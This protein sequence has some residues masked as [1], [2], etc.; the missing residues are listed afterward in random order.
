[1][2]TTIQAGSGYIIG[3][4][5]NTENSNIYGGYYQL[6]GKTVID[7]NQNIIVASITTQNNSI[8]AGTGSFTVGNIIAS[9]V[10]TATGINITGNAGMNVASIQTQNNYINTFSIICLNYYLFLT[11]SYR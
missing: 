8:N 2:S 3:K 7:S 5:Y 9:G 4:S 6:D 11:Q 1:M 10:I